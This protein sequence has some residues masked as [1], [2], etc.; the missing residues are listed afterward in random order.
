MNEDRA[1]GKWKQFKGNIKEQ[2]GKL[3]NDEVDQVEG[4]WDQLSG[5]IQERYG[6][7]RDEA[8]LEVR[9]FRDQYER[10]E[11]VPPSRP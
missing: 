10:G 1:E 9:R 7:A 6:R 5:L 4:K 8:D 11:S 2:W 3:T